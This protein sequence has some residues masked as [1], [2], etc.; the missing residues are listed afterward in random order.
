[1]R[2]L[3]IGINYS[4]EET[5]IAVFTA[6]RAEYLA[7]RGHEVT[8]CTGF[9][10]YP[11]WRVRE[12]YRGRLL[13][14]ERNNGVTIL[15]SW[16]YVPRR[17]NSIRRILHEAS[18]VASSLVR[19]LGQWRPDLLMVVSPPLALGLSGIFLSRL[20]RVPFVFHVPDL[21]PDAAVDLG[22][23]PEG[24]ITSALFALERLVYRKATVVSTLTEAMRRRIESKSIAPDKLLLFPDWSAPELFELPRDG[25]AEALR[26]ECGLEDQ[27]LVVHSGNMGVK[28][29]LD[30]ILDAAHRMR[31]DR[32]LTFLLVGDG[33]ERARLEAK[34]LA[35]KLANVR[36]LPLLPSAMFHNLL[37]ATDISLVTQQAGVGDIV[38][39]SKVTTIMA[40]GACPIVASLN[41]TSEVARVVTAAEAGLVTP[42]QHPQALVD[43]IRALRTNPGLCNSMKHNGRLYARTHWDRGLTLASFESSLRSLLGAYDPAR[44]T[45]RRASA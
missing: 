42:A 37:S 28:Q 29:G 34:C 17:V 33:A 2:I 23:L 10:Y 12:P 45:M 18:F 27:F 25:G 22:M 44:E 41:D 1:M 15:R 16:L 35:M 39:P 19:A 20:W 7:E 38:F 3:I 24:G 14:R 6:G 11:H 5:G 43:A 31:N 8:V 26:R 9:P 4:P 32:G 40:G 36:F 13:A 21:Q 30:V